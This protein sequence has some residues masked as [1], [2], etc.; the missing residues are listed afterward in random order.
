MWTRLSIHMHQSKGGSSCLKLW[1]NF[2]CP[3]SK[4]KKWNTI[5]T[6]KHC[7]KVLHFSY[8]MLNFIPL[9]EVMTK[10][11]MPTLKKKSETLS[12]QPNIAR[13][14]YILAIPCLTLPPCLKLWQNFK[15]PTS[16]RKVKHYLYNQTLQ[17][18]FTF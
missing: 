10:L 11:W 6:T 4:K 9:L 7:K 12:I 1:Q 2:K 14:F 16:K 5:P 15:C 8:P 13:K 18:S 3:P 17:E